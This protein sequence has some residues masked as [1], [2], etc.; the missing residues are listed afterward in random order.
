M[1]DQDNLA[2][3]ST[4]VFDTM[5]D[6][7]QKE[8]LP[9]DTSSSQFRS[10][11]RNLRKHFTKREVYSAF[12]C[13][14]LAV[15]GQVP[16]ANAV[17]EI[18]G[19]G[20]RGDVINDVKSWF[21]ALVA[22]IPQD[23]GLIPPAVRRDGLELIERLWVMA[24]GHASAQVQQDRQA[25]QD[26]HARAQLEIQ[27]LSQQA[28][29]AELARQDADRL[30][31]EAVSLA[32][33]LRSQLDAAE[34]RLREAGQAMEASRQQRETQAAEAAAEIKSLRERLDLSERQAASNQERAATL[35]A[36]VGSLKKQHDD[37]IARNADREADLRQRLARAEEL[38][39]SR[40]REW[41]EAM[42][43]HAS[44]LDKARQDI[45]QATERLVKALGE[46][47]ALKEQLASSRAEAEIKIAELQRDLHHERQEKSLLQARLELA[48]PGQPH[49]IAQPT[50]GVASAQPAKSASTNKRKKPSNA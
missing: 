42:R 22:R 34:A 11:I 13:E 32:E 37:V 50:S 41:D 21:S 29:T 3:I 44:S 1:P 12:I 18:G 9:D 10:G 28:A 36:Q 8:A 17:L 24:A 43:A 39:D 5:P 49:D 16:N 30:R 2:P 48:S 33:G 27:E 31:A 23:H 6:I 7:A 46:L 14:Q 40:N 38:L 20:S 45:T 47:S 4:L 25:Q 15:R 26:T 19:W 35:E